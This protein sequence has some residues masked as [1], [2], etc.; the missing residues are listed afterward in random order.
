MYFAEKAEVL[1]FHRAHHDS[2]DQFALIQHKRI[3]GKSD[4]N[5]P[6]A[7]FRFAP[8]SSLARES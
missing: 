4:I 7:I 6:A 8:E 5:A 2:V 3:A 1:S